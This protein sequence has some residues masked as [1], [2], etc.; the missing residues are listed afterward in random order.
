V[1]GT[2]DVWEACVDRS[3]RLTFRHADGKIILLNH[4]N[5]D[6]TLRLG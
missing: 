2:V 5:H 3:K 4:C 6:A 1:Q